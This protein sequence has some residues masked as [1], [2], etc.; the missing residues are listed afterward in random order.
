MVVSLIV[1]GAG[2][3]DAPLRPSCATLAGQGH[4]MAEDARS[5]A[6]GGGAHG[7]LVRHYVQQLTSNRV[8]EVSIG[9]ID[10]GGGERKTAQPAG[11]VQRRD[12]SDVSFH[13]G[14]I[15]L[16]TLAC[17]SENFS[18]M[19]RITHDGGSSAHAVLCERRESAESSKTIWQQPVMNAQ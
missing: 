6:H 3:K 13:V 11:C 17:A 4:E 15:I 16:Q 19:E 10:V 12:M 2:Q 7:N 14:G 8:L 1:C 5:P 18:L 9:I